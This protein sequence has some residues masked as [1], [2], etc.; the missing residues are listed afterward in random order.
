MEWM[1]IGDRL[2]IVCQRTMVIGRL[3][4]GRRGQPSETV[5]AVTRAISEVVIGSAWCDHSSCC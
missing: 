1:D 2:T 4:T 5:H 3:N